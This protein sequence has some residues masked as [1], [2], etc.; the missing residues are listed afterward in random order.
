MAVQAGPNGSRRRFDL[1]SSG[2][3]SRFQRRC[4]RWVLERARPVV[5]A[6]FNQKEPQDSDPAPPSQQEGGGGSERGA[7]LTLEEFCSKLGC[8]PLGRFPPGNPS[9]INGEDANV[10]FWASFSR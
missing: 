7:S 4:H 3:S 5:W 6:R 8:S 2:K 9:A 10:S 1:F